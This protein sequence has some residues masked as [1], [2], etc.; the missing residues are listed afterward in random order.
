VVE[1]LAPNRADQSLYERMRNRDARN[2][3]DFGYLEYPKVGLPLMESVQRIVIRAEVFRQTVPANG[4]VKH[5]AERHS[6]NGAAVDAKPDDPTRELVHHQENP[7]RS[8]H[9]RFASE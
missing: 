6:I 5:P 8:Q 9:C 7:M 2:G 1:V 3:L 4:P